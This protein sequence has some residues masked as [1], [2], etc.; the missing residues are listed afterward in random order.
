MTGGVI[1]FVF[2]K[3]A[4]NPIFA[5]FPNRVSKIG[6][7]HCKATP[8]M[9]PTGHRHFKSAGLVYFFTQQ[10]QTYIK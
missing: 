2:I 8:T 10:Y 1:I 3:L 4:Q 7:K 6:R 9:L 5:N